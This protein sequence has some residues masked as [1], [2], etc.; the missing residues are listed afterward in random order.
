[1]R[2]SRVR[3]LAPG[4]ASSYASQLLELVVLHKLTVLDGQVSRKDEDNEI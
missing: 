4:A 1:M 2:C 3:V